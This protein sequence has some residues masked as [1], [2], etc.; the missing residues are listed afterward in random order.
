MGAA[1]R[2]KPEP[3][4]SPGSDGTKTNLSQMRA[5]PPTRSVLYLSRASPGLIALGG[6]LIVVSA[7]YLAAAHPRLSHGRTT[8]V[9]VALGV[10]LV[11]LA[12]YASASGSRTRPGRVLAPISML[13]ALCLLL[14]SSHPLAFSVGWLLV[15]MAVS[16]VAYAMLASATAGPFLR[17]E[18]LLL[19][20][21]SLLVAI[22]WG[23]LA[24]TSRQ[25]TLVIPLSKCVAACPRNV[26]FV[27]SPLDTLATIA[28]ES[29]RIGWLVAALGVAVSIGRRYR[30]AGR[31]VR[32]RVS[33]ILVLAIAYAVAVGVPVTL[34]LAG[35]N[36]DVSLA[37]VS[38]TAATML[39]LAMLAGLVWERL[40]M[41]EAL[42][43]FV[44]GLVGTAPDD[45]P[46]LMAQVLHD[47]SVQIGYSR[48][49]S[50][51]FVDP[52]GASV[53]LPRQDADQ[54]V[55]PV[56]RDGLSEAVV[57]LSEAVV[58]HR[59]AV[60]DEARF[61]RAA[62]AAAL[63]SYENH[64]LEADLSAS[65]VELAASRKRLVDAAN[66][67]RQRIERDLHDG[68]QQRIVGAR[69]RLELAD[70]AL[71][72]SP[73]RGRRMIAEIGCD[74]DDALEE[75]RSL[76]QGVYPALLETHGLIEALRS[77]A[78]RSPGPVSVR[79]EVSR[80]PPD[81]EAAVYFCC[82]ETLQNVA[83]HAGRGATATVRL[84]EDGPRLHFQTEDTGVGFRPNG[85]RGH[86][87]VNMRDRLA[88]VGGT[89]TLSSRD[90]AGTVVGGCIP[91]A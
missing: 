4:S 61:I 90:G 15:G 36:I 63:M 38:V 57:S 60:P 24:L 91:L 44:N 1:T 73:A 84:W 5:A 51:G 3:V 11:A 54:E 59:D 41:G 78:R 22:S 87:L 33:P 65:V 9:W 2:V 27:G 16:L 64:R 72:S 76:A 55:T 30:A 26:F 47:P 6:G 13:W 40:F 69:V 25:P 52:S 49:A 71:D 74:L 81:T 58:I 8:L 86:G 7:G 67:E 80:Y 17:S 46:A 28:R 21:S 66:V 43:E 31:A 19:L 10:S 39:P 35:S 62:G 37:W 68:I 14:A 34:M 45:L 56:E 32:R 20:A 77:V 79:G 50:N 23:Y 89:L 75:V 18:R 88:A 83:K 82:L 29:L 70:E 85:T 12:L 42:E 48:P 53:E